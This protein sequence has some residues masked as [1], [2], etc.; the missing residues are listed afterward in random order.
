M[1]PDTPNPEFDFAFLS[2]PLP[3][4]SHSSFQDYKHRRTLSSISHSRNSS[5]QKVWAEDYLDAVECTGEFEGTPESITPPPAAT[6]T[7]RPFPRSI[8]FSE[9]EE[10]YPARQTRTHQRSL[11]ALLPFRATHW[12]SNSTSP[13]RSPAKEKS[14][15]EADFMPTLTGDKDGTIRVADRSKGLSSWFSGSSAPVPVGIQVGEQ[16]LSS[17]S[18][19]S[20]RDG[21]PEQ[22]TA[23]L[24][25]R[26]TLSTLH[27]STTLNNSTPIKHTAATASRFNFFSSPKTPNQKTIQL[28]QSSLENDEFLTIDITS[29]LF[30]NSSAQSQDPFSPSAFKNLLLNAEGLLQK[31]QTA[32]KLRTLSL[33]ELSSTH[34]AVIDELEEAETRTQCLR[35]QLE[36]MASKVSEQDRTISDLVTQLAIEKQARAEEKEAR[37]RSIQLVKENRLEMEASKNRSSCCSHED[38]GISNGNRD[39]EKW[40]QSGGSEM[41]SDAE[42]GHESVFSRSRSPTLMSSAASILTTESTPEVL[43][44][45]FGRVVPHPN[46]PNSKSSHTTPRPK[47]VDRPSTFQKILRGVPTSSEPER[48]RDVVDD[49]FGMGIGMGGSGCE[50]CRGKDASVAWDAVGLLR[51]ENR[52]LKD[53]VGSLETAVEGA[54]DLCGGLRL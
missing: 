8:P 35:S 53:R 41:S 46:S 49:M 38:L 52:G 19:M 17:P 15:Q 22:P 31:L 26:P 21:S 33:H 20:S 4:P 28:P 27:S 14:Q 12:R 6:L 13:Q 25:K 7:T 10:A 1:N 34:S 45:N 48:E 50:N 11:T 37:E 16:K 32:Y 9:D 40:R 51:A 29:A 47:L 18:T 43:Q 24:Q 3:K 54:L 30:P 36:D 5:L 44:A 23:K 2:T 39:R 42:S